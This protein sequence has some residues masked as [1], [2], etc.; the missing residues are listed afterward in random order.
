LHVCPLPQAFPQAPQLSWS[1]VVL[2][3]RPPQ[4]WAGWAQTQAAPMQT[5]PP[6]HAMPQPPQ[7]CEFVCV[8]TH[9][10]AQSVVAPAS[11]VLQLALHTLALQT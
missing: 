5:V 11:F 4:S 6:V 3:Q 10:P 8:F 9:A 7:S 1:T 2:T